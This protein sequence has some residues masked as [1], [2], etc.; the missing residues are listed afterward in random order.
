MEVFQ[1]IGIFVVA[2]VFYTILSLFIN[3]M[4]SNGNIGKDTWIAAWATGAI[5]F[6]IVVCCW[7]TNVPFSI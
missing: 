6:C 4:I 5:L 1:V 7:I 2:L 3:V